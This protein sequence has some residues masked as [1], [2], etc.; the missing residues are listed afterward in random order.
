NRVRNN[1][2][3]LAIVNQIRPVYVDFL[4]PEEQFP[5]VQRE[6]KNGQLT[7][8]A[9]VPGKPNG[10]SPGKLVFV[11]NAVD[12]VTEMIPFRARFPNAEETLWPGETINVT[13]TLGTLT[14]A[15]VVPSSSVQF[16]PTGPH[17][18]VVSP[19]LVVEQRPVVIC[20]RI[21][22]E[23]VLKSGVEAGERVIRS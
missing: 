21:G 8:I 12:M 1:E 17:L 23:T 10:A 6:M 15:V 7:V 13:L 22:G 19:D 11:D 20:D 18:F 2:T 4:I 9:A 5:A 16:G 14:N 3:V